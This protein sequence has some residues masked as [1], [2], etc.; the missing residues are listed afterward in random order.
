M[1]E[2]F[3]LVNR[4][5][6]SDI[7]PE[8]T[9]SRSQWQR[10]ERE[11]KRLNAEAEEGVRYKVLYLGR[12]GQGV[13]NVAERRYGREEWDR[14]RI[15]ANLRYAGVS[16]RF[17]PP[18]FLF[19]GGKEKKGKIHP[20]IPSPPFFQRYYASLEGDSDGCWSD[21]H[22]T[23]TGIQQALAVNAFWKRQIAEAKTPA[24]EKYYSSPLYRCLQTAN[25]TFTG[26]D[27]PPDRPYDPVVKE[28]LREAN[29]VHTCD[30]RSSLS[31]LRSSFP[32]FS[33]EPGFHEDDGLWSA[34]HRETDEELDARMEELLDD[35]FG[36]DG[37]TFLSFTS[38]SGAICSLLRVL[39]HREF[40]L[41]TGGVIPVLVKAKSVMQ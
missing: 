31:S 28:L 4:N 14:S 19:S 7:V 38:H 36:K 35:V 15:L 25:L 1:S 40:R 39:G 37:S 23:Q 20:L 27:L 33:F 2:N 11:V 26:L 30:R 29:G 16:P 6:S 17:P 22:L 12:H 32:N 10:F 3:G 34:S 9:T 18:F 13:H 24:P 21:A 41:V 8:E 5:D